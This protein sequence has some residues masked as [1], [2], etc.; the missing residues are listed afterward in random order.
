MPH[1]P[2]PQFS[3]MRSVA[4][5][6]ILLAISMLASSN[7]YAACGDYLA[8]SHRTMSGEDGSGQQTSHGAPATPRPCGACENGQCHQMP[9]SPVS[10][11]PRIVTLK[12]VAKILSAD[13][14]LSADFD[15]QWMRPAD[16]ELLCDPTF[17][18]ASP[19]P[20]LS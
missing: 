1:W 6:L 11:S 15:A 20:E 4:A 13:D 2:T 17:E 18:V 14:S 19:P 8:D 5:W 10:E 7:A 9:Y 12:E 3:R 16:S